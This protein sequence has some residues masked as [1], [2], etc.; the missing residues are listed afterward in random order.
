MP[1]FSVKFDV[2]RTEAGQL[3]SY[4]RELESIRQSLSRIGSAVQVKGNA[5]AL[6]RRNIL[7]VENGLTVCR[8]GMASMGNMLSRSAELY[9]AAERRIVEGENGYRMIHTADS[10][11]GEGAGSDTESERSDLPDFLLEMLGKMG[12]LGAAASMAA[13]W[14]WENDAVQRWLNGGGSL[15]NILGGFG[16]AVNNSEQWYHYLLGTDIE[17]PGGTSFANAWRKEIGKYGVKNTNNW[18]GK[19]AAGAKW[20]GDLLTVLSYGYENYQEYMTSGGD[21][22][23]GR[24]LGETAIE[25]GVDIGLGLAAVAAFSALGA[26]VA[27]AGIGA[28][29]VGWAADVLCETFLGEDLPELVSNAV[30]DIGEAIGEGVSVASEYVSAA[31][32]SVCDGAQDVWDN[33]CD[34]ASA[35]WDSIC[36]GASDW[37]DSVFG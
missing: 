28:V 23:I 36:D 12:I 11:P 22:S 33:V 14:F 20:A 25:S 34:G 31:W 17:N 10:L 29:A 27:I 2:L 6:I 1:Q 35:A 16:D 4:E 21:M 13:G 8:R 18:G 15:S 7:Q 5:G 30:M 9:E 19:L 37:W 24:A 3:G 32:D 26:P